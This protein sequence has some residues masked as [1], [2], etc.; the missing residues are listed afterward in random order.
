MIRL[1]GSLRVQGNGNETRF[2]HFVKKNLSEAL[3][4]C[5]LWEL[6]VWCMP[7]YSIREGGMARNFTW[8]G[9]AISKDTMQMLHGNHQF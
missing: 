5:F 1:T 7:C 8:K 9:V 4:K 3:D 6:Y 2:V